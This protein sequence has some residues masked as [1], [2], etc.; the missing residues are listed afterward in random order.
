MAVFYADR[1]Y[2]CSVRDSLLVQWP[3]REETIL[4]AT[5][6]LLNNFD[7]VHIYTTDSEARNGGATEPHV[8]HVL[9]RRLSSRPM[10]W[11]PKTLKKFVPILASGHCS[12]QETEMELA[13]TK[14]VTT[15]RAPAK[16][17]LS[18][19]GLPHPDMVASMPAKTGK[20]TPLY[21]LL[22]NLSK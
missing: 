1:D 5:N 13:N 19:L 17:F 2:F 21:R 12:F 10:G 6:Y 14:P 11:S 4:E 18:T 9:S 16:N 7:A 8:S 3:E 15:K 22:R 20:V